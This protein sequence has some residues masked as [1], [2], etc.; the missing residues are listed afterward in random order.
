MGLI[1]IGGDHT[2]VGDG[3]I[4]CGTALSTLATEIEGGLHRRLVHPRGTNT[5]KQGG[6]Q[7]AI[8]AA[9]ANTHR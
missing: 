7:A 6:G 2:L 9:S 4:T 3:D 5:A 8:T 1:T